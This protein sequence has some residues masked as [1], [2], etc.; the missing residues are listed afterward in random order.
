MRMPAGVLFP[1]F[2]IRRGGHPRKHESSGNNPPGN[3][4]IQLFHGNTPPFDLRIEDRYL[5]PFL[6]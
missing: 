4:E 5:W 1:F 3:N 2:G 6:L